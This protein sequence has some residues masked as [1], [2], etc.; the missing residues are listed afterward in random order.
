MPT[1]TLTPTE[2]LKPTDT[3]EP[4]LTDTPEPTDTPRPTDTPVSYPAV[5][6]GVT[7][8][9]AARLY[10]LFE[11]TFELET[12]EKGQA[13]YVGTVSD[14]LAIVEL[15]GPEGDITSAFVVINVPKPPDENQASRTIAYLAMLLT[16]A[17]EDWEEGTEWL[18]QSLNNMGES[19][20]T[21]ANR[22]I[23]LVITP[24]DDVTNV[25]FTIS[26]K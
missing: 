25:E 8:A 11:F 9:D 12:D 3:P 13:H 2:T 23:V 24:Q 21:Y 15:I 19:R 26:A 6:L 20:T 14:D 10:Q 4:T 17:A 7:R 22:E 16:V 5:G 18:N 1:D